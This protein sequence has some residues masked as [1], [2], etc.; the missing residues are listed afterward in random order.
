MNKKLLAIAIAGVVA[1]P[2]AQAQTA[3]VTLYGR[4]NL[5]AEV[6]LQQKQDIAVTANSSRFGIRGTESLG[7]GL[8]AIF[9]I[10][11]AVAGDAGGGITGSRETFVGLQGGWGTMKMGYFLSPYDDIHGI[12]GNAPT[13]LTGILGTQ[14]LWSNTG[15]PGNTTDTGSFDDRVGNSIR[16]DSPNLGGFTGSVQVGARDTSGGATGGDSGTLTQQR[17][18]A[19][20]ISTGGQ[21]NN[22]PLAV[23]LT[24]EVHNNLREG[25]VAVPHLQD[26]A[27]T[28]AGSWNFGIV[29]VAAMYEV[30]KYDIAAALASNAGDLKRNM[31]GLSATANLGPGQM[32]AGYFYAADGRGSAKC[33]TAAGI[34]TC[35]R[36]GAETLGPS[37]GAQQWEVSYTYPL[38]K[39]TLLYTGYVMID[40]KAN[41]AYNF[42]INQIAGTCTGNG[43]L[44]GDAGR[45][46]GIVAGMVHFF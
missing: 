9:Q 29:K 12:F 39:R 16:Y 37:S 15:Y 14:A 4:L 21:Y 31:W 22:G 32:Y 42:G 20:V 25:T 1:A 43:A 27:A 26:Q 46:Q 19:Y 6:I 40:N 5:D 7:G 24:Y 36:V 23:G 8:S 10:E 33:V 18:H 38:S 2:L 11:Y 3:N 34:T 13:L 45:P 41:G 44:C 35:P 30:N 28:I 17:R